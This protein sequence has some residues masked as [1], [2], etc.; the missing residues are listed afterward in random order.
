MLAALT[1][2]SPTA[3]CAGFR[4]NV[5]AVTLTIGEASLFM[6]TI[7]VSPDVVRASNNSEASFLRLQDIHPQLPAMAAV[8]YGDRIRTSN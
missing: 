7:A 5:A 1:A 8:S 6:N 2:G 4:L 3:E